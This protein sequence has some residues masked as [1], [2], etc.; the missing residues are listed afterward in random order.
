MGFFADSQFDRLSQQMTKEF[1]KVNNRLDQISDQINHLENFIDAKLEINKLVDNADIILNSEEKFKSILS[2]LKDLSP[3]NPDY[4]R[5]KMKLMEE[6]HNFYENAQ[7]D[8]SIST[9]VR[10]VDVDNPLP[11]LKEDI[12][13]AFRENV[14]CDIIKLTS[15]LTYTEEILRKGFQ[16]KMAYTVIKRGTNA[17]LEEDPIKWFHKLQK[18]Y[19]TSVI[20]CQNNVID[21]AKK[22]VKRKG[23]SSAEISRSLTNIYPWLRWAVGMKT[24]T[25]KIFGTN[26]FEFKESV[27]NT[28]FVVL[29]QDENILDAHVVDSLDGEQSRN[30]SEMCS[31]DSK[32]FTCNNRKIFS[33]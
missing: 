11:P 6:F 21:Y 22:I 29:W 5:T 10:M 24:E 26:Y 32:C 17:I 3:N 13:T 23:G 31:D 28:T 7:V 18:G 16:Q 20:H 25:T 1:E 27:E 12:F 15:L 30:V 19:Q 4:A 8:G 33:I 9:I 14:D 2:R